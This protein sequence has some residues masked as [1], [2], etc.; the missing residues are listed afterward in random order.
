MQLKC[1]YTQIGILKRGDSL[2]VSVWGLMTPFKVAVSDNATIEDFSKA[3][4]SCLSSSCY[5]VFL[6][7]QPK[8]I[9][10]S[11]D[12]NRHF[13]SKDSRKKLRDLLGDTAAVGIHL[14]SLY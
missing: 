13:Y 9:L 3:L 10:F 5:D 12:N 14:R 1:R 11:C 2:V 6:G 8:N 7:G 4:N